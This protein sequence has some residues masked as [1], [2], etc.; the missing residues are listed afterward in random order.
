MNDEGRTMSAG[1]AWSER[2]RRILHVRRNAKPVHDEPAEAAPDTDRCPQSDAPA[3]EYQLERR[4]LGV[5]TPVWIRWGADHQGPSQ[6]HLAKFTDLRDA[7]AQQR[8]LERLGGASPADLQIV[9][10][11]R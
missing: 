6:Y 10:R 2:P 9:V 7:Q 11:T 5:W 3:V 1:G 4:W 8:L